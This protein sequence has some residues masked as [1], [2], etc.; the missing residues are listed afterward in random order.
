MPAK[1][2]D[3]LKER[4]AYLDDIIEH[5]PIGIIVVDKKGKVLLMNKWQEKISQI[6]REQVL[7]GYFHEKWEKLFRQGIMSAYWQLLEQGTP[8]QFILHDVY[9][10][11]YERKISAISRGAPLKDHEA[12]VLLHD[13]SPEIQH[14]KRGLERLS[15]QVED[16]ARFLTNLIDSSPNIVITTDNKERIMSVNRTG[17]KILEYQSEELIGR[18]IDLVIE[19][20]AVGETSNPVGLSGRPL[21]V[22]GKKKSGQ[23]FPARMQAR[24]ILDQNGQ[25]Q[26][27]LYLITDITYEKVMEEKLA[28]TEKLAVYS[29]L[30]AG[31]AHQL[32]NPLV[33][34]AN[35]SSLLLEKTPVN[36]PNRELVETIHEASQRCR[37][38][39]STMIK[40]L[41]EPQSTFHMV[42]LDQVLQ[43]ALE[44]IQNRQ[45]TSGIKISV[46]IAEDLPYVRG[47]SIQLLEVFRNLM[48]NALQAMPGG[49]ELTVTARRSE[50][51]GEIVAAVTDTGPGIQAELE[52][53][54]FEPFFTT[55]KGTGLGLGLSFAFRIIQN[56]GG[57]IG[58]RPAVPQG[59]TFEV[60]LPVGEFA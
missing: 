14:D 23:T 26:A 47:D 32:N 27:D 33:G 45:V 13:V 2:Q 25:S 7:G 20:Q 18:Y 60:A 6:R 56:H 46:N 22:A 15:R 28:L 51:E 36:D 10:Q 43:Q 34:V 54:I 30:M 44:D 50:A 49:G 41:R 16:Q 31:V 29:E 12:F 35:F 38:M 4:L 17:E 9:P 58:V 42:D 37:D 59:S 19:E 40:S 21:E 11:F 53:Q 55:K 24:N 57:R 3:S 48:V 1:K 8:F 39:L 5:L 52:E